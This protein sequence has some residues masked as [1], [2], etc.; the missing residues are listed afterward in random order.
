MGVGEPD[1]AQHLLDRLGLGPD[2]A[3][4]LLHVR[5]QQ[6]R[7]ERILRKQRADELLVV[8]RQ[9]VRLLVAEAGELPPQRLPQQAGAVGL[10]RRHQLGQHLVAEQPRG[11][12]R[13]R[14]SARTSAAA[15]AARGGGGTPAARPGRRSPS[16]P[17]S[18]SRCAA[19]GGRSGG[20]ASRCSAPPRARRRRRA[21]PAGC[22]AAA[23]II[24]VPTTSPAVARRPPTNTKQRSFAAGS[25]A[26]AP[27]P[28]TTAASVR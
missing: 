21:A 23:K 25:L 12:A 10:E 8:L 28:R 17:C 6:R 19:R 26:P 9:P 22:R 13:C 20:R 5:R 1:L 15:R 11:G 18:C 24:D 3:D 2:L 14:G 4:Q 16:G 27:P 7:V